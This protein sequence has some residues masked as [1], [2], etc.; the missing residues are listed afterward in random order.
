MNVRKL[1]DRQLADLILSM[2]EAPAP[3]FYSDEDYDDAVEELAWRV[4]RN[5]EAT[6]E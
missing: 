6:P 1:T 4:V 5:A 2:Q 3:L